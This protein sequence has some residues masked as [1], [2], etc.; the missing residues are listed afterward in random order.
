MLLDFEERWQKLNEEYLSS[1]TSLERQLKWFSSCDPTVES[2]VTREKE[3]KE[4]NKHIRGAE[5]AIVSLQ[6]LIRDSYNL[7]DSERNTHRIQI[8]KLKTELEGFK[9]DYQA[10][11]NNNGISLDVLKSNSNERQQLLH[12]QHIIDSTHNALLRGKQIISETEDTA[13]HTANR[14]NQQGQQLEI[15]LDDLQQTNYT[16]DRARRIMLGMARRMITDRI[17]QFFIVIIELLIIGILI[18]YKFFK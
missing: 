10:I 13:V 7:S 12:G 11:E 9:K 3:L 14:L 5:K 8:S 18:W 4:C 15:V 1:V 16:Q 17:I 2:E 6:Q